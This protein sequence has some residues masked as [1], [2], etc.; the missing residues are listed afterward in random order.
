MQLTNGEYEAVMSLLSE[1]N[2]IG[3]D[4]E[5]SI[6]TV[7]KL[8]P[9]STLTELV[10]MLRSS[11]HLNFEQRHEAWSRLFGHDALR[12]LDVLF[13]WYPA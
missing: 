2:L 10:E 6:R 3:S 11:A 4:A 7:I 5:T 9:V 13:R 12:V 1:R 8:A